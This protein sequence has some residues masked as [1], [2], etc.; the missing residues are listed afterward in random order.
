LFQNLITSRAS[1]VTPERDLAYLTLVS[2]KDEEEEERRISVS[3]DVPLPP[4]PPPVICINDDADDKMD[5]DEK[6]PQSDDTTSEATLVNE[7]EDLPPPYPG[8]G[9][10][11]VMVYHDG[12]P[13]KA[14]DKENLP[15][16]KDITAGVVSAPRPPLQDIDMNEPQAA[17]GAVANK[18]GPTYGPPTPPPDIPDMPDRPPPVPPRPTKQDSKPDTNLMFGRQQDVTECIGNVM[19]Q[20]EAAIKPESVDENG[21][22]IDLVK[23]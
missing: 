16:L 15:P 13:N 17:S 9:E 8:P 4:L 12:K 1:S 5:I 21:E 20:V 11:Y 7:N 19:F 2:S 22:Q 23:K 18:T 6:A 14:D 10:D 3:Y